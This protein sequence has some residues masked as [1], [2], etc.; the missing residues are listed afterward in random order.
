[1]DPCVYTT[2]HETWLRAA[3]A[4]SSTDVICFRSAKRWATACRI[5][6]VQAKLPVLFRQQ[7]EP[8]SELR[9]RFVGELIEIH[10][11]DQF[12]DDELRLAW[13]EDRL[14]LQR[15]TIKSQPRNHQFPT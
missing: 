14:W 7:D 6:R 9:C 13:L 10:F 5:L 4:C 3:A 2:Q 15:E 12:D 8:Q 11:A 1:M